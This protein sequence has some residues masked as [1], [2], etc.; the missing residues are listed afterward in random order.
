[1]NENHLQQPEKS[2]LS[3]MDSSSYMDG[4]TLTEDLY[5]LM[6][7]D[8]PCGILS[9][10]RDSGAL[11]HYKAGDC[12]RTHAPFLGSADD[13]LM[14]KWWNARA[15]PASRKTML[16]T[17]RKAGYDDPKTYLA[18]N[19]ALSLTDTYWIRP[20][21]Y[22][23]GWNDVSLYQPTQSG[24]SIL[25]YHNNTSYDPNATL[26]GQMDKYWDL[27][28]SPP[29][30]VKTAYP[31]YGQQSLNEA[32]ATSLHTK[33]NSPVSFVKYTLQ[34]NRDN[35]VQ[36]VCPAFTSERIEF[37]P[38]LEIVESAKADNA[39]SVYDHFIQVCVRHGISEE[40]MQQFMDYQ[41]L[42]DFVI[43]N[44]DE[45]LLNFGVLRDADTMKL[46]APAPIF[47]SGNSMFHADDR[48]RPY[49]R[50]ELL[51]R[52]ITGIH[53]TEE[54]ML[55][56]VRMKDIVRSDLLPSEQ[57]VKSFYTANGLP[58]ERADFIAQSYSCKVK[59][60]REFQ[61]GKAISLYH[62]KSAKA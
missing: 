58:E 8:V 52:Q 60:L 19:L 2:G 26:G 61:E 27:S 7:K 3:I 37:V 51:A 54:A 42:T 16:E 22:D 33:Q 39:L 48:T 10:D 36:S 20:I 43:S 57:E 46:I 1:M 56:H 53:S 38:A 24:D 18:K 15:V 17:I 23:L 30:L 14:K 41:T 4:T 6:H 11:T 45:H 44:T 34:K 9:I 12:D 35:G 50:H 31:H 28:A 59:M 29:N 62:E 13:R 47:D 25:P 21:D 55:R 32:F 40:A 49:K 5:V